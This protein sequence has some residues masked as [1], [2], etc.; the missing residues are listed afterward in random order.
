MVSR[1][2][3]QGM[4]EGDIQENQEDLSQKRGDA[5]EEQREDDVHPR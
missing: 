3:E 1:G 2:Y 5:G 4:S